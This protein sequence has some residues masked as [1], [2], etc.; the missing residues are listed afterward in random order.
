MTVHEPT[1]TKIDRESVECILCRAQ[2]GQACVF[3]DGPA[4][5]VDDTATRRRAVHA[6]RYAE[7]LPP[8]QRGPFWEDAVERYLS[9]ELE[10][11]NAATDTSTT[12][13]PS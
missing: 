13:G 7:T 9:T 6:A 8:D 12:K 1:D 3:A 4:P 2:P 11:M 5:I 10:R